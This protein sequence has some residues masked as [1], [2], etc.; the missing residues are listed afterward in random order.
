M[1]AGILAV[2]LVTVLPGCGGARCALVKSI[3]GCSPSS[4]A[5][6]VGN[7]TSIRFPR[8]YEHEPV[9]V[10][11][12]EG[13]FEVDG[14]VLQAIRIAADD[15]LP[16]GA[17]DVPCQSTQAAHTY[18]VLRRGDV[19]FVRMDEDPTACGRAASTLHSGAQYAISLDGRILRR[20]LDGEPGSS[21]ELLEEQAPGAGEQQGIPPTK[22]A[23]GTFERKHE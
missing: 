11:K 9:E 22:A 2:A 17:K 16:R 6:K 21:L 1:R 4:E 19:L 18:R 15:F 7:D 12:G 23:P 5:A 10:A 8:F 13:V 3:F 14:S 20:A